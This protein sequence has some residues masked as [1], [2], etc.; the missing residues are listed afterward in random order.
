METSVSATP[1]VAAAV[2]TS[3]TST[4]P[5]T[6]VGNDSGQV[7]P[8][9]PQP[10]AAAAGAIAASVF[11]PRAERE[12]GEQ[13]TGAEKSP[14]SSHQVQGIESSRVKNEEMMGISAKQQQRHQVARRSRPFT[15]NRPSVQTIG[16]SSSHRGMG[17]HSYRLRQ[18][19]RRDSSSLSPIPK[20]RRTRNFRLKIILIILILYSVRIFK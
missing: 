6:N 14:T 20:R 18:H 4:A 11:P 5:L 17:T 15:S 8:P 16:K 2:E 10:Q 1:K 13:K 3:V 9:Q 12:D 19:C 7:N